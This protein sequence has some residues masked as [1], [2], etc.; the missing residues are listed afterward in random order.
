MIFTIEAGVLARMFD[1][2]VYAA[3][4]DDDYRAHLRGVRWEWLPAT[5]VQAPRLRM[6]ATDAVRLSRVER[7]MVHV[8][9]SLMC[10]VASAAGLAATLALDEVLHALRRLRSEKEGSLVTV[11]WGEHD[12]EVLTVSYDIPIPF[13]DVSYPAHAH[14]LP[15]RHRWDVDPRGVREIFE[16]DRPA[17]EVVVHQADLRLAVNAYAAA[18]KVFLEPVRQHD[19]EILLVGDSRI[20]P[21]K[22]SAL[23][24]GRGQ[25][26]AFD[27]RLL[28]EVLDSF[29]A[30]RLLLRFWGIANPMVIDRAD[31]PSV[32]RPWNDLP[33][34]TH[35]CVIA[36]VAY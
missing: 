13:L 36:P 22:V 31:Q 27:P 16:I 19:A 34:G 4:K 30:E 35:V 12:V 29:D 24:D 14:L 20:A 26:M 18:E 10:R 6:T 7:A 23:L 1:K 11:D 8:E 21:M 5:D 2:V 28:R 9:R 32:A 25:K 17:W 33:A 3:T 15:S